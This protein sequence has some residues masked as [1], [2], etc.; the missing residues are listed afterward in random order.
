M[1][2]QWDEWGSQEN[3]VRKLMGQD[4]DSLIGKTKTAPV[5]VLVFSKN[6]NHSPIVAVMKKTTS[7]PAQTN[8]VG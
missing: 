6:S 2:S 1:T 8:T 4:K 5:S 3:K 7:I